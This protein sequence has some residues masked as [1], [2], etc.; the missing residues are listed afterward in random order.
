[1]R[2]IILAGG[3]G[4][5]LAPFTKVFPKPMI[6]IGETPIVEILINNLVSCGFHDLIMSVGYLNELIETYFK[7][8][9]N[10]GVKLRYVKES[11]PLGTA[12]PLSVVPDLKN[13]FLVINGDI[14]TDL[15]FS[16][17]MKYHKESNAVVTIAVY[18]KEIKI[19]FGVVRTNE[20]LR[21]VEY[22]EKPVSK[23]LIS[24]GI[25]ICEPRVCNYIK[26]KEYLDFPQLV[27]RLLAADE[28][29][30][31]Y[32]FNGYWRDI[33]THEEYELAVEEFKEKEAAFCALQ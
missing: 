2:A 30:M 20:D 6:P 32:H 1:M 9:F 28:R 22:K 31:P 12:G 3:K 10:N 25:Y 27:H 24:M 26:R 19:E 5:R 18:Q 7:G 21:I 8:K 23:H 33:G 29:V 11:K 17:M 13:T 16:D 4:K 15:D 14:L